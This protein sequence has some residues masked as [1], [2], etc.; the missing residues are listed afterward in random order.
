MIEK[1]ASATG[2]SDVVE[3]SLAIGD[4]ADVDTAVVIRYQLVGVDAIN[5]TTWSD[6][7]MYVVAPNRGKRNMTNNKV[8]VADV[9][10]LVYLIAIDEIVPTMIDYLGLDL[11][12]SGSFD[13]SDLLAELAIWKGTGTLLAGMSI[14]EDATAKAS[15]SYEATDKANANLT[16]NI[17]NSAAMS[18]GVFK[19][20]YD[21][22][23]FSFGEVKATDRLKGLTIVSDAN[24]AKGIFTIVVL[25][26]EGGQIAKGSGAALN[27]AISAIGDKF[28]G[29]GEISLLNAEFDEGV[30]AEISRE[31]LSPKALL[32][33]AFA[34]SQNYPNPFNPS[35]TIAYDIPEGDNVHVQ[36]NVYNMRGQLVRTLVDES[37]SEGSYQIQW[38]GSD[39]YGRRVSS[40]VYFY[41]IKAGEF[42]KTRK[43][44]ILK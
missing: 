16:L 37:K 31:A 20:K 32:P 9:M 5:D 3:V 33:K 25:N 13:T 18:V 11:D 27:I 23:K 4:T 43:M 15:L 28:D 39:N 12:V 34:M 21:K 36:L 7:M 24:E 26:T 1:A 29:V 17:D 19:I 40:G 30:S 14:P 6:T 10:R 35:T 8:N 44:V 2:S 22:D 42:S 41:R 38:D